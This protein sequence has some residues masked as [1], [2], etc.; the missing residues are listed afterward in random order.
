MKNKI[1]KLIG[2]ILLISLSLYS[3]PIYALTKDETVYGKLNNDGSI[4]KV[5]VQNQ[6]INTNNDKEI[7]DETDLFNILNINGK[8]KFIKEENKITWEYNGKD[9]YYKGE[10]NKELPIKLNI[11]YYQNNEEKEL[12]SILG[13][14]GKFKIHI[15]YTNLDK[16]TVNNEN[17][18]TPFLVTTGLII[19]GDNNKNINVNNGKVINNGKD[20]IIVGISTPG[21]YESLKIEELKTLNEVT[22]EFE[23]TKFELPNIYSVITPKIIE[24]EDLKIFD[25]MDELYK[26]VD[27]LKS[28]IEEI[29]KGAESLKNG[30]VELNDG[31]Q[32]I[33][34]NLNLILENLKELENGTIKLSEGIKTLNKS[35]EQIKNLSSGLNTKELETLIQNNSYMINELKK[36]PIT[37]SNLIT[38]LES[39]NNALK[40][41]LT[42]SNTISLTLS[43]LEQNLPLLVKGSDELT[44][45]TQKLY[46]GVTILTEKTKELNN[47]IN[48]LYEGTSTLYNGITQFNNEGITP[49]YNITNTN[50]KTLSNKLKSLVKLSEDYNTFTIKS[51]DTESSTKFILS[52]DG[53]KAKEEKK[54]I[55]I[56]EEKTSLWTKIKN[57][58]K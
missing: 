52:I 8:E 16:H 17:L 41:M 40:Q 11:K 20:N 45:V 12:S 35:L 33:Y 53:I 23:S 37:N 10:T 2:F 49:I 31:T 28:G 42:L 14:S 38:L 25:K 18:Y 47:G 46:S 19:K 3:F 26:N 30:A 6:L 4:K 44:D 55:N 13:Q 43:K 7:I 21:L 22:I 54:V 36:D 39:N 56:K 58:F 24:K 32:K 57:L 50:I 9:I 27:T 15:I 29:E 5:F 34:D 1:N 48:S 51:Q